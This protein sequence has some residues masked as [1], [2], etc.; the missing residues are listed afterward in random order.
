MIS[1]QAVEEAVLAHGGIHKNDKG[2]SHYRISD[3]EGF[4]Q[5]LL[6]LAP[7]PSRE[8]LHMRLQYLWGSVFEKQDEALDIIM[9]WATGEP[10]RWCSHIQWSSDECEWFIATEG[11]SFKTTGTMMPKKWDICPVAG[12]HAPRPR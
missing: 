4:Y 2:P 12:C 9:A 6:A 5:S 8:E 7:T 1:R 3:V 10:A 11:Q